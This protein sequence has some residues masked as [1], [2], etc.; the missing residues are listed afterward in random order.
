M[1]FELASYRFQFSARDRISFPAGNAGNVLRGWFGHALRK[2]APAEYERIFE[3]GAVGPGPSGLANWPRPFVFRAR[4]LNGLTVEAGERLWFGVNVFDL[5][6]PMLV[7]FEAAFAHLASVGMGPLRGHAD[8]IGVETAEAVSVPLGPG[9]EGV[10]RIQVEFRSPTE[11]KGVYGA[12]PLDID[13]RSIGER[14][15]AVRLTRSELTHVTAY[16]RSSRSGQVH[17]LGGFVGVAEYE[18]AL[19]E[20]LPYLEAAHWTGVGRQCVWGK[21]EIVTRR[22]NDYS[23]ER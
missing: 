15:S 21:G 11:L 18:G 5:R 6:T 17:P 3:P 22:P 23:S 10:H 1:T 4:H 16:R 12:G 13:F 8:L 7:H 14:A 19:S 9:P 20:F 2:A